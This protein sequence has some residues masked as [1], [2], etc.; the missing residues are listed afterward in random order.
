[1][2]NRK[3]QVELTEAQIEVLIDACKIAAASVVQPRSGRG[4][5]SETPY[6]RLLSARDVL[7]N[8]RPYRIEELAV[9]VP[10]SEEEA[11]AP[12]LPIND[13]R[14]RCARCGHTARGCVRCGR[15]TIL[16]GSIGGE[17]YCHTE[18]AQPSCYT[19][20]LRERSTV[21]VVKL[22][23]GTLI[24]KRV[25]LRNQIDACKLD[26][27]FDCPCHRDARR[28]LETVDF[29]LGEEASDGQH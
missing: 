17:T 1:M 11:S 27:P 15:N 12:H 23:R 28:E 6:R 16:G 18:S 4:P 19:L 20:T 21:Q 2:S 26:D 7:E 10:V 29:L 14:A 24:S 13:G 9:G 3:I 8:A 5:G 25:V 22:S